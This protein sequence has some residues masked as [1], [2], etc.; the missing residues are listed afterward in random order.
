MKNNLINIKS[1]LKKDNLKIEFIKLFKCS[2]IGILNIALDFSFFYLL[3][4]KVNL[5]VQLSQ[6]FCYLIVLINGYFLNSR[7]VFKKNEKKY[8]TD[9]FKYILCNIINFLIGVSFLTLLHNIFNIDE[10][11]AKIP[12]MLLNGFL[13]YIFLRFVVFNSKNKVDEV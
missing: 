3:T 13:N 5:N 10:L 6:L 11:I 7:L 2:L 4:Q 9:F 1:L 8:K 12:V